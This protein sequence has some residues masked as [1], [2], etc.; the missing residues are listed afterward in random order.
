[1][2]VN[3]PLEEALH[4]A[5]HVVQVVNVVLGPH[6][7]HLA[8]EGTTV[9]RVLPYVQKL[10]RVSSQLLLDWRKQ[11]LARLAHSEETSG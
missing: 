8:K 9:R 5:L 10:R 11:S 2:R 4:I 7:R 1:M 3:I 6:C